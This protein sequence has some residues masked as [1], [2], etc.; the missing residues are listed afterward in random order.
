MKTFG[1][2]VAIL[3][4]LFCIFFVPARISTVSAVRKIQALEGQ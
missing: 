4:A 1:I 3:L 2:V